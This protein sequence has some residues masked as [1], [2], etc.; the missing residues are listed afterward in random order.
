M[1]PRT[2]L[3]TAARQED[4]SHSSERLVELLR[5]GRMLRLRRGIYVATQAWAEAPPWI[6]YDMATAAVAMSRAP[7]F[8]RETALT[9]HGLPVLNTPQAVF[10]RTTDPGAVGKLPPAPMTG[11]VDPQQFRRRY[12]AQHSDAASLPPA[13]LKNV[14]TKLLEVACPVGTSR[15]ELRRLV[16][17]D[18]FRAPE[19]RLS[20]AALAQVNG[21]AVG[22]RCE[23]VGLAVVD[24]V[25]RM[26]FTEAV[27]VLDAVKARGDVELAPWLHYLRS[28]RQQARWQQA[29]EFADARAESVLESESRVVLAQLGC[30]GPSLQRVIR[31]PMGEFRSDFC[32][33][34]ERVIG[35]VDGKVKYF[36]RDLTRGADPA[37]VHYREKQRREALEAQGWT[38]V[39]WGKRE[40]RNPQQLR[41]RLS[42]VG[43]L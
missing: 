7:L 37:E 41:A 5:C 42:R 24:A 32:W 25:S 9:L 36:S 10:V 12:D 29:W 19:E 21:P 4:G 26:P 20:P 27:V 39:R 22:Y 1:N 35:E 31:T 2:E 40:L 28:Q 33:E 43:L 16:R 34:R 15:A 38:V 23:P 8:C 11:R 13:T 18:A 17:Q 3:V 30:L 6:R 14:P